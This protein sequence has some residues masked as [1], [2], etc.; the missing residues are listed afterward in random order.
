MSQS[1]KQHVRDFAGSSVASFLATA[2]DG[3]VFALLMTLA[4]SQLQLAGIFA[5]AAAVVGGIIHYSLCRF[6][7]FERFDASFTRSIPLYVL[8]S[9]SAAVAHGIATQLLV[10]ALAPAIAWFV[11]K[12]IVY[13]LWTY[14]ASRYIVFAEGKTDV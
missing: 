11:S 14:P 12:A 4:S 2:A 9:A 7:V 8:M 1:S 3:V 6:W 5:A 10:L 13:V